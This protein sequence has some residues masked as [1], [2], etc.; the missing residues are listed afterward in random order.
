M[1]LK[2]AC[3]VLGLPPTEL[4]DERTLKKAYRKASLKHHPD[5]NLDDPVSAAKRFQQVGAAYQRIIL[6]RD[7]DE[8][9]E[10][11]GA[12]LD[13]HDNVTAWDY[14][15]DLP[16]WATHGHASRDEREQAQDDEELDLMREQFTS[17]TASR[18]DRRFF[19]RMRKKYAVKKRRRERLAKERS[20]VLVKER[21]KKDQEDAAFWSRQRRCGSRELALGGCGCYMHWH[22][23]K[24][25]REI[26]RRKINVPKVGLLTGALAKLLLRDDEKRYEVGGDTRRFL[27]A[28]GGLRGTGNGTGNYCRLLGNNERINSLGSNAASGGGGSV[29]GG[30]SSGSSN[31]TT[32]GSTAAGVLARYSSGEQWKQNKMGESSLKPAEAARRKMIAGREKKKRGIHPSQLEMLQNESPS[33][34]PSREKQDSKMMLQNASPRV[35][36]QNLAVQTELNGKFGRRDKFSNSKQRYLICFDDQ[37]LEPVWLKSDNLVV[38]GTLDTSSSSTM[39]NGWGVSGNGWMS[40]VVG[41][42]STMLGAVIGGGEAATVKETESGEKKVAEEVSEGRRGNSAERLRRETEEEKLAVEEWRD[43]TIRQQKREDEI[44]KVEEREKKREKKRA[45]TKELKALKAQAKAE[46]KEKSRSVKAAQVAAAQKAAAEEVAA[47]KAQ[48]RRQ[49]AEREAW[50]QEAERQKRKTAE[51]AAAKERA[52]EVAAVEARGRRQEAEREAWH[53]EAE[54]Q[55][56]AAAEEAWHQEAERQRRQDQERKGE[57]KKEN[58][59]EV[60]D[61]GDDEDDNIGTAASF[62][63][64]AFFTSS[65]SSASSTSSAF[66]T[67]SASS[68]SSPLIMNWFNQFLV[69][70]NTEKYREIFEREECTDLVT[71]QLLQDGDF[72]QLGLSIGARH[73]IAEFLRRFGV[74][75]W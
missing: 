48:A 22:P 28:D 53:Q 50:H 36:V 43:E 49:E 2:D 12:S 61:D 70:T 9:V 51:V 57:E 20:G 33:T 40:T 69:M 54:R 42:I 65:A 44:K 34:Q 8:V 6:A 7:G 68:A 45:K 56:R 52:A 1:N 66:S 71:L 32:S 39:Q 30:A 73:R 37:K 35:K 16:M 23:M 62:A 4:P 74:E 75:H 38:C 27:L 14:E 47:V 46:A 55:K 11:A 26:S 18:N 24:L 67:S 19:E 31:S 58:P 25:Q 41:G 17:D 60:N 10:G 3:K 15:N 64:S 5:R 59:E 29:G 72:K 13:P 21:I 63:S